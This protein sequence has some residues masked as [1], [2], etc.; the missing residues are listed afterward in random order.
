M[1]TG[2]RP[3]TGIA[4]ASG[5]VSVQ[6]QPGAQE[7]KVTQVS[8]ECSAAPV[9]AACRVRVNGTIISKM[10]PAGDVAS[11][12]P[13]VQLTPADTMTVDWTGLTTGAV[14]NVTVLYDDG[15]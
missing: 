3:Y 2:R 12:D 1:A 7:W 4:P 10:L 6:V 14:C 5:I 11:G 15:T 13:P 9:G 8:T